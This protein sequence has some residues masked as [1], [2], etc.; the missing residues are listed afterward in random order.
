[1]LASPWEVVA[2]REPRP[3]GF[4]AR[5]VSLDRICTA[6]IQEAKTITPEEARRL[7]GLIGSALNAAEHTVAALKEVRI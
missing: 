1:M 7:S 3:A 4:A 2:P 6:V 5:L